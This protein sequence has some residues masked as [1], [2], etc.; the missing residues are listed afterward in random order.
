M[1][2]HDSKNLSATQRLDNA[3][4]RQRLRFGLL[5]AGVA[6]VIL[7]I[8]SVIG[9]FGPPVSSTV[10]IP[11][12]DPHAGLWLV[13]ALPYG[14]ARHLGLAAAILGA[15]LLV[16]FTLLRAGESPN[17]SLERTRER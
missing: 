16:V 5:V 2:M 17:K 9:L 10:A 13:Q 8:V 14:T 6:L 11:K 3:I 1:A 4:R 12:A 7:G 15:L